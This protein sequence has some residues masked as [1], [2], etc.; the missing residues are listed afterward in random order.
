MKL[1]KEWAVVCKALDEG[2]QIFVARKG[3]IAEA[4]G[5]FVLSDRDFYLLPGYLH[6]NKEALKPNQ[7]LNL[8]FTA[9]QEPRDGKVHIRNFA[10]VTDSWKIR[11]RRTLPK[12]KKEHIW[13]DQFLRERFEWGSESGLTLVVLRVFRLS[14]EVLL[15]MRPEYTGCKSWVTIRQELP[16]LPQ[17]PVLSDNEFAEKRKRLH[18]MIFS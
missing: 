13:T 6:Q 10:Q 12:L 4:E 5:E 11:D 2:R 9:H 16:P 18:G 15:P 8:E 14:E 1:L 3:G 7:Y 17:S